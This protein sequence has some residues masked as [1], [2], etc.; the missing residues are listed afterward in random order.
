M[1]GNV[2][3]RRRRGARRENRGLYMGG[4]WGGGEEPERR[5]EGCTWAASVTSSI[6]L[7]ISSSKSP[8]ERMVASNAAILSTAAR[9]VSRDH[10]GWAGPRGVG[11]T[12]LTAA[13][14]GWFMCCSTEGC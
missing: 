4:M 5:T 13:G 9:D 12:G 11:V 2:G 10:E 6:L 1:E 7:T 3:R 14:G 8:L